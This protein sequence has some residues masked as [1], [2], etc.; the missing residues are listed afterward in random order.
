MFN[1]AHSGIEELGEI[2][3][4]CCRKFA[5]P[6]KNERGRVN[7]LWKEL[8]LQEVR[9]QKKRWRGDGG[10]LKNACDQLE[11]EYPNTVWSCD[12]KHDITEGGQ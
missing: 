1:K 7:R 4:H 3:S 12:F 10:R 11:P 8:G 6:L 2:S 5:R 9:Q